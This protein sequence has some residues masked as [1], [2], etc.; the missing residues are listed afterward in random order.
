MIINMSIVVDKNWLFNKEINKL[1]NKLVKN[2]LK[3]DNN[4]PINMLI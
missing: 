3:R 1:N 4:S 2:G